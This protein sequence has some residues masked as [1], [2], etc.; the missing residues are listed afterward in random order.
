M[1]RRPNV[2]LLL[3]HRLRRWPDSKQTWGQCPMFAGLYQICR[4]ESTVTALHSWHGT[5]VQ[6]Q[7]AVFAYFTSKQILPFGFAKNTR[8]RLMAAGVG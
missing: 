8:R 4:N 6:S 1:R 2:G 7:R 3:A 5:T